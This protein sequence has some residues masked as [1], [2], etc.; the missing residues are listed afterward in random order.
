MGHLPPSRR[1]ENCGLP[2][3]C[4]RGSLVAPVVVVMDAFDNLDVVEACV[5]S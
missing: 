1:L 3:M 4:I 5:S 2:Y